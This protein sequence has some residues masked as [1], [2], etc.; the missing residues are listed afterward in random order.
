MTGG[1]EGPTLRS[2]ARFLRRHRTVV[3][4]LAVLG[5]TVGGILVTASPPLYTAQTKIAVTAQPTGADLDPDRPRLVSLDSDAQVLSSGAVLTRAAAAA[6]FPGG[7]PALTGA[8]GVSAV[9]NS[10]VLIVRVSHPDRDTALRASDAVVTEFLRTRAEA[11]Q[12]REDVAAAALRLQISEVLDRLAALQ[13]AAPAGGGEPDASIAALEL[14]DEE[15]AR[16]AELE[17]DLRRVTTAGSIAAGVVV[18]PPDAPT[19]GS[20]SMAP[21]TVVAGFLIGAAT[22]VVVAATGLSGRVGT[23]LRR[24]EY[25]AVAA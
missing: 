21:A 15:L 16:L 23:R 8:L 17:G 3:A 25:E 18:A 24:P 13:A 6:A 1:G 9:P 19:V 11:E 7:A 5:A 12:V 4:Y 14:A 20:L 2:Y 10:Q 22:G